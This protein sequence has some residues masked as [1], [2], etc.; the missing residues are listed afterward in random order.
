M[1]A[2]Y[3][4]ASVPVPKSFT[5]RSAGKGQK[6]KGGQRVVAGTEGG[7]LICQHISTT[8]NI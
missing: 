1:R 2:T 4:Q 7:T 3:R 8:K 5:T 6:M